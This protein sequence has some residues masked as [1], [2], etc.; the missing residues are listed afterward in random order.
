[1]VVRG[2]RE[3][4]RVFSAWW[5]RGDTVVA[6]MHANDWDAISEVRRLVGRRVDTAGLEDEATPLAEVRILGT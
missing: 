2:H 6:G 5:L 3:G 1:V 4:D